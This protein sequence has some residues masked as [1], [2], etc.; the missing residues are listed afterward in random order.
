MLEWYSFDYVLEFANLINVN[1]G[2]WH[3]VSI[4]YP[5][6]CR[7]KYFSL[8]F[9]HMQWNIYSRPDVFWRPFTVSYT[10]AAW[11]K[12]FWW[13]QSLHVIVLHFSVNVMRLNT[14]LRVQITMQKIIIVFIS[15]MQNFFSYFFL[16]ICGWSVTWWSILEIHH[17]ITCFCNLLILVA[18]GQAASWGFDASHHSSK[19]NDHQ[20]T[21]ALLCFR[22]ARVYMPS[23]LCISIQYT[24]KSPIGQR[25]RFSKVHWLPPTS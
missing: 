23:C 9:Q 10:S 17:H 24:W 20:F 22:W 5:K 16:L 14:L 3:Q 13:R 25:S 2:P 15:F 12:L 6:Q 4:L 18:R 21:G 1:F 11:E 7:N 8:F 19:T